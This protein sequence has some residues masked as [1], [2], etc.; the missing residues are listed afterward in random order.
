MSLEINRRDFLKVIFTT[1]SAAAVSGVLPHWP[2]EALSRPIMEP[3]EFADD[4][5]GYLIDPDMKYYD[6]MIPCG[7]FNYG[8]TSL[9]DQGINISMDRLVGDITN[10]FISLFEEKINEV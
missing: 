10:S 5:Y 2:A 1:T 7:I 6:G 8:V 9:Q 3:V 4:G